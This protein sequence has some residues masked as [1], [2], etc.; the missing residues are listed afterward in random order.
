MKNVVEKKRKSMD[1]D[2]L[3]IIWGMTQKGINAT[4]ISKVLDR[5]ERSV[6]EY[7]KVLKAIHSEEPINMEN[8]RFCMSV[9]KEYCDSHSLKIPV[10][11][12]PKPAEKKPEKTEQIGMDLSTPGA[13]NIK[14]AVNMLNEIG[15]AFHALAEHLWVNFCK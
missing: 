9:I 11:R 3:N 7:V 8:P 4:K 2:T 5:A 14:K 12:F 1:V 15:I 10:I 6:Q 13:E